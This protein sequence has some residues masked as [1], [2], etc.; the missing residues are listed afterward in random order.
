V[1]EGQSDVECD[2]GNKERAKGLYIHRELVH[3]DW[4]GGLLRPRPKTI[5]GR[6]GGFAGGP[7]PDQGRKAKPGSPEIMSVI[8]NCYS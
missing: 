4:F 6:R 2:E 7:C 1:E 8:W 5:L 3:V